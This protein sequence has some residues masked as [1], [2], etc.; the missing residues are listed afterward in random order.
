MKAKLLK[1]RNEILLAAWIGNGSALAISIVMY[2]LVV[3]TFMHDCNL[4]L[5]VWVTL[6]ISVCA[7]CAVCATLLFSILI[8]RLYF[9]PRMY[10]RILADLSVLDGASPWHKNKAERDRCRKMTALTLSIGG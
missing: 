10:N 5:A 8:S 2:G 9:N 6:I 3:T 1:Y 4:S 7:V